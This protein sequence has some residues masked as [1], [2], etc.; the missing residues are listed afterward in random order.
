M[1]VLRLKYQRHSTVNFHHLKILIGSQKKC[2]CL[3]PITCVFRKTSAVNTSQ[4]YI[5]SIYF[6]V[7]PIFFKRSSSGSNS[8]QPTMNKITTTISFISVFR[9][10]AIKSRHVIFIAFIQE[11]S[12]Q[13]FAVPSRLFTNSTQI[14]LI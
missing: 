3:N 2:L 1:S 5:Q 7:Y 10:I 9:I 4:Q 14:I 11:S 13:Y 8:S 12:S 6:I